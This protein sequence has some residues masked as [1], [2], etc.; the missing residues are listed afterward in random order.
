MSSHTALS[1]KIKVLNYEGPSCHVDH[2]SSE[3][4][5]LDSSVHCF[6]PSAACIRLH[7]DRGFWVIFNLIPPSLV[8]KAC[9]FFSNRISPSSY[10]RHPR[11]TAEF[12]LFWSLLDPSEQL[13]EKIPMLSTGAFVI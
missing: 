11:V 6:S 12:I 8:F 3:A 7:Q 4:L 9:D 1:L 10:W 2:C 13:K 5:D